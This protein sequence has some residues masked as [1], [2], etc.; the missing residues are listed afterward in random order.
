MGG[1]LIRGLDFLGMGVANKRIGLF[2]N[3]GR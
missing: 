3:G 2:R 1:L